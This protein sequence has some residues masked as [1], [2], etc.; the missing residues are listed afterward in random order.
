MFLSLTELN[1]A[2][3]LASKSVYGF[4]FWT[5]SNQP[6]C[7]VERSNHY[8]RNGGIKRV[9]SGLNGAKGRHK[10]ES[11]NAKQMRNT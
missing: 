5:L 6:A 11:K 4:E 10:R 1:T 7:A 9:K 8:T 2:L 3:A